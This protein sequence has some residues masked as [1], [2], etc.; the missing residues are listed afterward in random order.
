MDITPALAEGSLVIEA[1]GDG[2]FR[3]AGKRIEGSI[4]ITPEAVYPWNTEGGGVTAEGLK[5]VLDAAK[6]IDILLVGSGRSLEPIPS[7]LKNLL[8]EQGIGA[9]PMD[10]GA[11]CRTYNVLLS[12]DR[13]VAVALKAID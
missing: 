10:T 9:D 2:G 12:E 3:V 11:A 13:R 4:I 5:P 1:Y 7:V 8:R 6:D